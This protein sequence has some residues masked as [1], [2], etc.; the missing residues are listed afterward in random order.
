MPV[1]KL[2]IIALPEFEK[3]AVS[4]PPLPFRISLPAPPKSESLPNPPLIVS[5]PPPPNNISLPIPPF[6]MLSNPSPVK[7]SLKF[8]PIIFSIPFSVSL[9]F[10]VEVPVSKFA[11][12]PLPDRLKSTVSLP[13]P[14]IKVSLPPKP[15]SVSLPPPPSNTS[16]PGVPTKI[17]SV[18]PPNTGNVIGA[19]GDSGGNSGTS[20]KWRF[21]SVVSSGGSI[22]S[23]GSGPPGVPSGISLPSPSLV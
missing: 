9:P 21:S 5:A 10:P 8:D 18:P 6:M 22:L 7:V 4:V 17:S 23:G 15:N 20:K 14:P 3:S 16:G 1:A 11:A 19:G 13:G 12:T 2:A